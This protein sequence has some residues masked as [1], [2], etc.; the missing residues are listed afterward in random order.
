LKEFKK[1]NI[2]CI[3]VGILWE[4]ISYCSE[5]YQPLIGGVVYLG[6]HIFGAALDVCEI[7]SVKKS[8]LYKEIKDE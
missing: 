2:Y 7:I 6:T 3:L 8:R 5:D 1:F 4:I